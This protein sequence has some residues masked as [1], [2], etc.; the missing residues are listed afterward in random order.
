VGRDEKL[1]RI[2][3]YVLPENHP[4]RRVFE[5]LGFRLAP[6]PREELIAAELQL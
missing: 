4:M 2:L 5:K 1:Q 6:E 3:G